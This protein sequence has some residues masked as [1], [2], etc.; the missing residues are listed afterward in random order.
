MIV[1]SATGG[2]GFGLDIGAAATFEENWVFSAGI[3]NVVSSINWNKNAEETEYT[4]AVTSFTAESADEDSTVVSDET[5][6]SLGSFSTSLA[7][8]MNLGASYTIGR[9]LLA[10]DLKLGLRNRAGTS[11]TPEISFGTEFHQFSFMPL[12]AGVS[13]GGVHGT[14][15]ALGGGFRVSS[16]HIDLAWASSGTLLPSFGRGLSLAVSSGLRF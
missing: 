10:S 1:R 5:K 14:S 4:F 8:Q 13:L 16:F 3:K 11:T 9:F 2:S 15:L 6:R 12:R 7:P